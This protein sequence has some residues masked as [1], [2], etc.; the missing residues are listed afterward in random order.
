[1]MRKLI[2]TILTILAILITIP[3]YIMPVSAAEKNPATA[4]K[5]LTDTDD[6]KAPEFFFELSVDGKDVKEVEQGD[7]ITVVLKLKRTDSAEAYTMYAMQ[8]EIRYDSTFLEVVEG[9]A[10]LGNGI[11]STDIAMVDQYREFYMNYLSM[12]GG[13][14]WEA[15]TLIGSIQLRVI[16]ESGVTKITS[17]DYLVSLQDGSGSYECEA[18]DVTIILS[19]DC[20]VTF[21]TNG[22]SELEELIVQFGEKV[23]R[24]EDPVREGYKLEGWYTDIHMTEEWDFDEDTVA[25]NMS[26][27]AKWT[28]ETTVMETE[29]ECHWLWLVILIALLIIFF[30]LIIWHRKKEEE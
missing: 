14:K 17:Q 22:G 13:E 11:G 19:T 6:G 18:N 27:Y 1:M 15:D 26:L 7:I 24:P 21:R 10:V 30:I 4:E 3:G 5:D 25:G 23:S 20:V 8:D 12:R 16:G 29:N 9:S 2:S 28:A